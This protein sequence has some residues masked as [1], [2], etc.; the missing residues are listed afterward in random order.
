V[1]TDSERP[2]VRM[3][4]PEDA[5]TL[6]RVTDCLFEM[7]RTVQALG[8]QFERLFVLISDIAHGSAD[9]E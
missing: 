2:V 8:D 1:N 6:V 9:D 5:P 7:S 3:L 4:A